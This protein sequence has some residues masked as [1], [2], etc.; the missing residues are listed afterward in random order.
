[1]GQPRTLFVY[2]R[3]FQTQ[4]D[5]KIVAFSGIRTQIIRVEGE[6]AGYHHHHDNLTTTTTN[7]SLLIVF[8]CKLVFLSFIISAPFESHFKVVSKIKFRNSQ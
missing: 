3:S 6:H 5:R 2:F 7:L 1:M 8:L 4:F